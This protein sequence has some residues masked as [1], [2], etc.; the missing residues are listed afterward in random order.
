[1]RMLERWNVYS[2]YTSEDEID[3]DA[4]TTARS[5]KNQF[6]KID[7]RNPRT[8]I[9]REKALYTDYEITVQTNNIAF[10]SPDSVVRRRYSDFQWLYTRLLS[11]YRLDQHLP[12]LPPKR[13]FGRFKRPFL[14]HRQKGLQ[15]FLVEITNEP[16]Y[17][18]DIAVHLFL[19][20][21]LSV[22]E[23]EKRLNGTD[24]G[25]ELLEVLQSPCT[26][27][28]RGLSRS[29]SHVDGVDD[30]NFEHDSGFSYSTTSSINDGM[31]PHTTSYKPIGN[32]HCLSSPLDLDR[33]HSPSR[34]LFSKSELA[35][36][37]YDGVHIYEDHS[38]FHSSSDDEYF[39]SNDYDADDEVDGQIIEENNNEDCLDSSDD[40][41]DDE[42][43]LFCFCKDNQGTVYS[44]DRA[45]EIIKTRPK[46]TDR[47]Y[48]QEDSDDCFHESEYDVID[49]EDDLDITEIV[50]DDTYPKASIPKVKVRSNSYSEGGIVEVLARSKN[51]LKTGKVKSLPNIRFPIRNKKAIVGVKRSLTYHGVYDMRSSILKEVN[52]QEELLLSDENSNK[53]FHKKYLSPTLKFHKSESDG[54]QLTSDA[55][56]LTTIHKHMYNSHDSHADTIDTQAEDIAPSKFYDFF[57]KKKKRIPSVRLVSFR[58]MSND[59]EE[60]K[61][62]FRVSSVTVNE[63]QNQN[64]TVEENAVNNKDAVVSNEN[65]DGVTSPEISMNDCTKILVTSEKDSEKSNNVLEVCEKNLHKEDKQE[66]GTSNI[67][68]EQL[69][70][71]TKDTHVC[72]SLCRN[73]CK[74][75]SSYRLSAEEMT[76]TEQTTPLRKTSNVVNRKDTITS[77]LKTYDI[78]AV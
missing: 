1:M 67:N 66:S 65:I 74:F 4:M 41:D 44:L 61:G 29:S 49:T 36:H 32:G 75:S 34:K 45:L 15:R 56:Y 42:D 78:I 63:T 64:N 14:K 24:S 16:T 39:H 27:R 77:L 8:H 62:R 18:S 23:I 2:Y 73:E 19:Q 12:E 58:K 55:D 21:K 26:S 71:V 20:T 31:A 70:Q 69:T 22:K 59:N 46:L 60:Q 43:E 17:L 33:I 30:M 35:C 10:S 6:I 25:G 53:K 9:S 37:N 28:G 3:V 76:V 7:V 5:C 72:V 13:L 48:S 47:L 38:A 57:K 50:D 40:N 11:Q 54:Q 52:E 68:N 51:K